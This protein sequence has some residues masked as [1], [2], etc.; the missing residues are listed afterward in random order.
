MRI[1]FWSG[2]GAGLPAPLTSTLFA[3]SLFVALASTM[4]AQVTYLPLMPM[5]A[6]VELD[7][8]SLRIDSHFHAGISGYQDTRLLAAVDRF[9]A[10]VSRQ[11][12][13]PLVPEKT[14]TLQIECRERG[15]EYPVL[16][17]DESY[18]LNI[19]PNEARLTARTVTG[20]IR[21]LETF[22]QLIVP[23]ADGF[24][25]PAVRIEDQPRFRWRGLMLDVSRHWMPVAVV[26][27]NLD[28]M[29][30]VKLNVF[31]WHLSDDQ[32]F[33][34]ESKRFPRLVQLGSDGNFYTQAEVRQVVAYARDRGIRVVPEFDMPGHTTAWLV[35]YPEL[36]SAPGPYAIERKW[37]VFE[38]TLDPS[39]ETTYAFLDAL[40]GEMAAL[41]PDAYF[42][43]G[44]DEVDDAQWKRSASIQAF[45]REHQLS[46]SRDLQAYFNHRVQKILKKHGKIMI[47]WDEV[48]AP[49]LASDTVIQ[50][51]RGPATLAE[52]ANHGYASVLS[53]GYYLDKLLPAAAH[54]AVDPLG[55]GAGLL[56][57]EQ[58][59][60]IL[61]AEAC[62]WSEYV[63]AETVDSRVWPRMAAIAERFWSPKEMTDAGSLY[64]RLD[65]VSRWLEWTG[66][67]HRSSVG[68][69]LDRLA[70]GRPSPALRELAAV[71]EALGIE[72]RRNLHENASLVPLNR[73][74]DAVAPESESARRLAGL[75][76]AAIP[77][78]R[79]ALL[80]WA[81]NETRLRPLME[82]N[83]LLVEVEPLARN[84]SEAGRIGLRALE[85]L[86]AGRP[87]PQGWVAEN[88]RTLDR[89]EEPVAQVRL[90]A[91]RVV[92]LLVAAAGRGANPEIE[93]QSF[94]NRSV[95]CRNEP[96]C[97][98]AETVR[99]WTARGS[100]S[101]IMLTQK[102]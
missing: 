95:R 94:E 84:L 40:I 35:G 63:S 34:V 55:D 83:S 48:L 37:G 54:Y 87:A 82:S 46:T 56:S 57:P 65:R 24:E 22:S 38:P 59:Q 36:A 39:R 5:P 68:P 69:M 88:L 78:L 61:G 100:R 66:I 15:A 7:A 72:G 33:R 102:L 31:H 92:R 79:A 101:N 50:S 44:G 86:E 91:V 52:A 3:L 28:A 47:G 29:A 41:F 85:F 1:S 73:F 20:I 49:E 99:N 18:R 75:G 58:A 14:P 2:R 27:R 42:H 71:S 97:N 51:W 98:R 67:E 60:H 8:G 81:E 80:E 77:E 89:L 9:T 4:P 93:P 45:A 43:I 10:R 26:E 19:S 23:G 11:T 21:G 90:A 16:D 53:F 25:V 32:G 13:I 12:G 70:G 74:V 64:A 6:K 17:E 30:A 76:S 62:M 96:P